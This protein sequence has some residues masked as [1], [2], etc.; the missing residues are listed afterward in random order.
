MQELVAGLVDLLGQQEALIKRLIDLGREEMKAL[1]E[2]DLASLTR[3]IAEQQDCSEKLGKLEQARV[4]LQ[5]KLA[6]H[7]GVAESEVTVSGLLPRAGQKREELAEVAARLKASYAELKELNETNRLLIR[8][9]LAYVN[10]VLAAWR[11]EA[12]VYDRDG[13]FQA[14]EEPSTLNTVV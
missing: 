13:R 11:A 12:P 9:A 14:A 1:K 4:A 6:R 7:L 3:L 10:K 8:Q 5:E 2:E